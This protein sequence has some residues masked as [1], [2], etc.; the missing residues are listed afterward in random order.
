MQVFRHCTSYAVV[1]TVLLGAAVSRHLS[2]TDP[3][4]ARRDALQGTVIRLREGFRRK[5]QNSSSGTPRIL[6]QPILVP[7]H[8]GT[9][10]HHCDGVQFP[11]PAIGGEDAAF[12]M[13]EHVAVQRYDGG[14][15]LV[16]HGLEE[17]V[18]ALLHL[19]KPGYGCRRVA[20]GSGARGLLVSLV[21]IVGFG[22]EAVGFLHV[23]EGLGWPAAAAAVVG[24]IAVHELL[25]RQGN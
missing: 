13:L 24:L 7:L 25:L 18:F 22:H 21:G 10:A 15:W 9:V 4:V 2:A 12:I 11:A 23:L 19:L 20:S 8:G 16:G 14:D 3:S 1:A 5:D 6:Y 17:R